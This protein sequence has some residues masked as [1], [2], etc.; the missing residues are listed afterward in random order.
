[1]KT[2]ILRFV[3]RF[4]P[5][6]LFGI[7]RP[8]LVGFSLTERCPFHCQYC[9]FTS[10]RR[11]DLPLCDIVKIIDKLCNS[12]MMVVQFTGGEPCLRNDLCNIVEYAKKRRLLVLLSTSGYNIQNH[13]GALRY[14][15]SIQISLDGPKKIHDKLRGEGSFDIVMAAADFLKSRGKRFYFRSVLTT[16]NLEHIIDVITIA[17]NYQTE[18][19]FQPIWGTEYLK[20]EEVK[21]LIPQDISLDCA[22]ERII[23]FKRDKRAVGDSLFAIKSFKSDLLKLPRKKPCVAGQIYF[24]VESNGDIHPCCRYDFFNKNIDLLNLVEN[25]EDVFKKYLAKP[26]QI[27]CQAC[28]VSYLVELNGLYNLN[29]S[30]IRGIFDYWSSLK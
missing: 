3:F 8:L 22:L 29:L 12:G 23:D 10:K 2:D 13:E 17:E 20:D 25:S 4:L 21:H 16:L 1:M 5:A 7:K 9:F 30:A 28:L 15:D 11:R 24:R 18:A 19:T 27:S 26:K 6:R 14:I